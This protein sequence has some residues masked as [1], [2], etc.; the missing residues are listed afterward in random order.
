MEMGRHQRRDM[1]AIRLNNNRIG[2][3]VLLLSG[4]PIARKIPSKI[5]LI[6]GKVIKIDNN[7]MTENTPTELFCLA[8]LTSISL[9][10]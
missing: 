8:A 7:Q 4:K 6:N 1:V 10:K 9:E 2:L 5:G 3:Q